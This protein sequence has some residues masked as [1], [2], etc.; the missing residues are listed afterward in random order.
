M[1]KSKYK[2]RYGS[3]KQNNVQRDY[4]FISFGSIYSSFKSIFLCYL[5]FRGYMSR[6]LEVHRTP[7]I[8]RRSALESPSSHL[9]IEIHLNPSVFKI[10]QLFRILD[11]LKNQ[12]VYQLPNLISTIRYPC[13]VTGH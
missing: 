6:D 9:H 8:R 11:L 3:M 5:S 10:P 12:S 4:L 13:L 1:S 7:G 2:L